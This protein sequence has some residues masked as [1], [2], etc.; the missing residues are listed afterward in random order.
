M[1]NLHP[2]IHIPFTHVAQ[3]KLDTGHTPNSK[4]NVNQDLA[5][6]F[7]VHS[8]GYHPNA[9]SFR[10]IVLF[11]TLSLS[12]IFQAFR[13]PNYRTLGPQFKTKTLS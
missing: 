12:D 8:A 2:L 5:V 7:T 4:P 1:E 13:S 10:H 11:S 3:D 6:A 9:N